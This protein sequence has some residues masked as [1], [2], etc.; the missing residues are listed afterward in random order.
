MK[1]SVHSKWDFRI[2]PVLD[3]GLQS[4]SPPHEK[5]IWDFGILPVLNSGSQSKNPTLTPFSHDTWDFGI[6]PVLYSKSPTMMPPPPLENMNKSSLPGKGLLMSGDHFELQFGVA[7]FRNENIIIYL[8]TFVLRHNLR[9]Q[10]WPR[11][12]KLLAH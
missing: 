8:R 5:K 7:S 3:S 10:L 11:F 9:E 1:S 4:K 12:Q 6:L 2:S